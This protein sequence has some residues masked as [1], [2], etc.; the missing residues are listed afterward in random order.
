MSV[1]VDRSRSLEQKLELVAQT[2]LL[3]ARNTHLESIVQRATDTGLQVTGAEFGSFVCNQTAPHPGTFPFYTVS[4]SGPTRSSTFPAHS[5]VAA[6]L[7]DPA[8][9]RS[10]D[11][12]RDTRFRGPLPRRRPST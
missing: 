6:P 9:I 4:G 8:I 2:G 12:G 7:K 10:R 3:L 11:I 1:T 5:T